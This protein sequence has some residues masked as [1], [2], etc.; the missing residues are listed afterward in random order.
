MA[1]EQDADGVWSDAP[2]HEWFGLSHSNYFV[3]PRLA[4]QDLPHDWQR[5]FIALMDEASNEH[6]MKTPNY[7]VLRTG[8]QTWVTKYDPDDDSSRDYVF[9]A[10]TEDPWADY[11]R[12]NAA[13]CIAMDTEGGSNAS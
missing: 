3:L 11:R 9:T 4:I 7:H 5:R 10:V 13:A 8:R 12:G 6:G 2:I 1:S